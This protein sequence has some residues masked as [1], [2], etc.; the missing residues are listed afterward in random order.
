[1]ILLTIL[2]VFKIFASK[3]AIAPSI[4]GIC[5]GDRYDTHSFI[6]NIYP[7]IGSTKYL[8]D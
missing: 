4:T 8:T 3:K 5:G 7:P 1:M 2:E 6:L